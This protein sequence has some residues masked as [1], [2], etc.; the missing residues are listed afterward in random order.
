MV[1][2][3]VKL[4]FF[5]QFIL[6]IPILT[7]TLTIGN[8]NLSGIFS[9]RLV[10]I[11]NCIFKYIFTTFVLTATLSQFRKQNKTK[12]YV[13]CLFLVRLNYCKVPPSSL[14]QYVLNSADNYWY[15]PIKSTEPFSLKVKNS[16]MHSNPHVPPSTL[17]FRVPTR[18]CP[19]TH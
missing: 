18:A 9:F 19:W 6:L 2:T 3:L 1:I 14:F 10:K 8:L 5:E 13:F 7:S 17:T 11:S 12:N 16:L 4:A 15:F